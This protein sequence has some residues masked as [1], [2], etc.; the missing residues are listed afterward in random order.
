LLVLQREIKTK[1]QQDFGLPNS[2][3]QTYHGRFGE[4]ARVAL[5]LVIAL[6]VLHARRLQKIKEKWEK[7][8]RRY[9]KGN[10]RSAN[11]SW[12][13]FD[14]SGVRNSSGTSKRGTLKKLI[15][16]GFSLMYFFL[17]LR[18]VLLEPI[19]INTRS[20]WTMSYQ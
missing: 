11:T 8:A 5:V 17:H 6:L 9:K 2:T 7:S 12:Y 1:Q 4:N 13:G 3:G 18:V 16:I 10:L 20:C 19:E 15:R 14:F